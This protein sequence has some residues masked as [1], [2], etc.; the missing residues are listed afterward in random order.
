MDAGIVPFSGYE[1]AGLNRLESWRNTF[2]TEAFKLDLW[3]WFKDHTGHF[4]VLTIVL[5]YGAWLWF[6]LFVFGAIFYG[7][8]NGSVFTLLGCAIGASV[9]YVIWVHVENATLLSRWRRYRVSGTWRSP[10]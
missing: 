10:H 7:R 5:H 4:P 1:P 2:R 8:K 9:A 3:K 6:L